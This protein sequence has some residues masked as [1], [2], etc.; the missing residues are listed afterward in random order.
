[1]LFTG[2]TELSIDAK[3]RLAIPSRYRTLM[4]PERDGNAWYCVPWPGAGGQRTLRLYTERRFET[5]ADAWSDEL[6]PDAD[7][8][9]L[10]ARFFSQAER[11]EPDANGR[12]RIPPRHLKLTRLEGEVTLVG[13]KNRLEVRERSSWDDEDEAAFADLP[14]LAARGQSK[15]T[16]PPG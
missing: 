1:L 14:S 15:R 8:A 9:E 5:L 12:I 2:S 7:E 10:Q 13:A 3:G 6:I 16:N 4:D 11:I